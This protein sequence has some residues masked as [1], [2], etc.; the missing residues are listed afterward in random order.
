MEKNRIS[1]L[2]N[3]DFIEH[4]QNKITFVKRM[5]TI[6]QEIDFPIHIDFFCYTEKEFQKIK[7]TSIIISNELKGAICI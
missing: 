3:F 5:D 4:M 7:E 2:D 6:L 1:E